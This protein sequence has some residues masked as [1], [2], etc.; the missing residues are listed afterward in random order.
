MRGARSMGNR[1]KEF[2]QSRQCLRGSLWILLG[3][4]TLLLCNAANALTGKRGGNSHLTDAAM[5]FY[6][7]D[8]ENKGE[9]DNQVKRY[10]L[11]VSTHTPG[12]ISDVLA[13]TGG[14]EGVLG[15][16][17]PYIVPIRRFHYASQRRKRSLSGEGPEN[18][19][20]ATEIWKEALRNELRNQRRRGR[21]LKGLDTQPSGPNAQG[22]MKRI[23]AAVWTWIILEEL[24]RYSVHGINGT[25]LT[26][27][28]KDTPACHRV[29][30]STGHE[31]TETGDVEVH[32]GSSISFEDVRPEL[33]EERISGKSSR[34]SIL[35][36][37]KLDR[38]TAS[39][40]SKMDGVFNFEEDKDVHML[41]QCSIKHGCNIQSQTNTLWWSLDRIDQRDANN[42]AYTWSTCD[43]GR[44]TIVYVADTGVRVTHEEFEDR[45]FLGINGFDLTF[46]SLDGN[47][48][49]THVAGTVAGKTYGVSKKSTIVA[50]KVL[51]SSGSGSLL[52]LLRGLEWV[53]LVTIDDYVEDLVHRRKVRRAVLNLSL[54]AELSISINQMMEELV[55]VGI[56]T[57]VAAGNDNENACFF[58]PASHFRSISV[59]AST[60]KDAKA[61]FSNAGE[62]V[63]VFAPG[64][65][66]RSAWKNS[67]TSLV[68]I[69]GTS[70]ASPLVAGLVARHLTLFPYSTPDEVAASL[71]CIATGTDSGGQYR[72]SGVSGVSTPPTHS[73]LVFYP[74]DCS[75]NVSFL[76]QSPDRFSASPSMQLIY[77]P[78][79]EDVLEPDFTWPI[80][81]T[82]GVESEAVEDGCKGRPCWDNCNGVGSCWNGHCT[83]PCDYIGL[84]CERRLQIHSLDGL[85]GSIIASNTEQITDD[86]TYEASDVFFFLSAEWWFFIPIS[87]SVES[88]AFH[89]C[90]DETNFPTVIVLVSSCPHFFSS[91][92]SV[93][94]VGHNESSASWCS[95]DSNEYAARVRLDMSE[96]DVLAENEFGEKGLYGMVEG[97]DVAS[98]T[99][100]LSWL[101][102]TIPPA[103]SPSSSRDP[104]FPDIARISQSQTPAPSVTFTESSSFIPSV[105][106]SCTTSPSSSKSSSHSVTPSCSPSRTSS[107]SPTPSSTSISATPS[108]TGSS[109]NTPSRTS[110]GSTSI[111][112]TPSKT[113]SS[114]ITPS[115]TSSGTASISATPSQTSS[116]SN[117][118][119]RISSGLDSSSATGSSS[120]TPTASAYPSNTKS[121]STTLAQTASST[122]HRSS[123]PSLNRTPPPLKTFSR[124]IPRS[125]SAA[126]TGSAMSHLYTNSLSAMPSTSCPGLASHSATDLPSATPCVTPSVSIAHSHTASRARLR[127]STR[128]PTPLCSPSAT[129]EMAPASLVTPTTS[130]MVALAATSPI[131]HPPSTST[132]GPK[133]AVTGTPTVTHV[134]GDCEACI[135]FQITVRLSVGPPSDFDEAVA[136][137]ENA[138]KEILEDANSVSGGSFY[139]S[140]GA[141]STT[142]W[143]FMVDSEK[144]GDVSLNNIKADEAAEVTLLFT[145][146]LVSPL[147][148]QTILLNES[149]QNLRPRLIRRAYDAL[150]PQLS[151]K[152]LRGLRSSVG[153][154]FGSLA[155]VSVDSQNVEAFLEETTRFR[156]V[157][158]SESGGN[159]ERR[160]SS[161]STRSL[162]TV[163]G[164]A[165]GLA[166]FCFVAAAFAA[167]VWSRMRKRKDS[168]APGLAPSDG[169]LEEPERTE[170]VFS[171]RIVD[172]N[173][174]PHSLRGGNA[175][176]RMDVV[177]PNPGDRYAPRINQK[178]TRTA[179]GYRGSASR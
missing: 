6:R 112:A 94:A 101:V 27:G 114:S 85:S 64:T 162:S 28:W 98:G 148:G 57:V 179:A 151:T 7:S 88:V 136:E 43:D 145:G 75:L 110:S 174:I 32:I 123:V 153:S 8:K 79:R 19:V 113:G 103:A 77:W 102:S 44:D 3:S 156:F 37:V 169:H 70:M 139:P 42:G 118:P 92:Y 177:V 24:R 26:S 52:A 141:S 160:S 50:V 93:E 135:D 72:E 130:V 74:S 116:S 104:L 35:I 122:L 69:Q 167:V 41:D 17:E 87:P 18:G 129:V 29:K 81:G 73:L 176:P 83:C 11:S 166:V 10:I 36:A 60:K 65:N 170:F 126:P 106:A 171:N 55:E 21:A 164:I 157:E 175:S 39:R 54:G 99:F 150:F 34:I 4:L 108:Q 97:W 23:N 127:S 95:K 109:S 158:P 82:Y 125:N 121:M 105:S 96:V 56:S 20:S 33:F 45:A 71:S 67:D 22:S 115:R 154:S 140:S 48:H 40:V 58:S 47:G 124:S 152:T 59:G 53:R 144:G 100:S 12:N 80:E 16:L 63:D 5:R 137:L 173:A 107:V 66:I 134:V 49:G 172:R 138:S 119:L 142:T 2:R 149:E 84:E 146:R 86:G 31:P 163:G 78:V 9:P 168:N 89:T 178:P 61:S 91:P 14:L 128:P 30:R 131:A 90:G 38:K 117:T 46:N 132:T 120:M 143:Q 13:R 76:G 161:S 155:T 1:T 133:G 147:T 62:C 165:I 25:C 111:S 159:K 15:E 68:D 51:D